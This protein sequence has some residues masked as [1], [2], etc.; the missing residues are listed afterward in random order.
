V[1]S[2]LDKFPLV[3]GNGAEGTAAEAAAMGGDGESYLL[4]GR[5]RLA[6]GGMR[7]TAKR[8][9]IDGIHGRHIQREGRGEADHL[10]VGVG[11]DKRL[12]APGVLLL[13]CQAKSGDICCRV[14]CNLFKG[15]ESHRCLRSV[16]ADKGGAAHRPYLSHASPSRIRRATSSSACSACR[17]RADLL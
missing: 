10:P 1:A 15:W 14:R 6:V 12:P 16:G 2:G 7:F 9:A 11:L 17:S 13:F 4:K 3:T 8:E 5:N